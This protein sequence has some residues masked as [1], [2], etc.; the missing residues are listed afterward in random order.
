MPIIFNN[1]NL[2]YKK[3]DDFEKVK[4][5]ILN[6][7]KTLRFVEC[8][9]KNNQPQSWIHCGMIEKIKIDNSINIVADLRINSNYVNLDTIPICFITTEGYLNGV[10]LHET[11]NM[12]I[13]NEL[14]N[15]SKS[16]LKKLSNYKRFSI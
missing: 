4:L 14:V 6:I 12:N 16:E 7:N 3:S 2:Y 8:F 1:V 10:S 11:I 13:M 9:D 5:D 15:P